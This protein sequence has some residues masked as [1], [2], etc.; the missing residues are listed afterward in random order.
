MN[1]A[2]ASLIFLGSF[3]NI[4]VWYY[5]KDMQVFDDDEKKPENKQNE[6]MELKEQN[7]DNDKRL[8]SSQ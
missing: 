4:G 3:W 6:A 7:I 2:C 5:A 8:E 1:V